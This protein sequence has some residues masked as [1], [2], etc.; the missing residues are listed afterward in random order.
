MG[1]ERALDPRSEL[2]GG[3]ESAGQS[4]PSQ[5][6]LAPERP[7]IGTP[8]QLED[9]RADEQSRESFPASDAPASWAGPEPPPPVR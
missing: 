3:D 8:E 9:E 6:D 2:D 5:G 1:K 7:G 4:D